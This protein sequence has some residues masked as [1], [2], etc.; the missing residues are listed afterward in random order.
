MK[1][2]SVSLCLSIDFV[3]QVKRLN[4]SACTIDV[5]EEG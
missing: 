1:T 4:F 3:K 5:E 2:Y